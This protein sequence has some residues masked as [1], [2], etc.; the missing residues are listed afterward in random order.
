MGWYAVYRR[1]MLLLWKKIGRMGYVFPSIISPFIYFFAFGLGL[2]GRVSVEG[3]YLP[4]LA[5]GIIGMTVMTSGFQQTASS[6]SAG[7]LY[8]RHFHSLVLS[9][10]S[11]VAAVWGVILAG[12]S[13]A[14]IFGSLILVVGFISF[15]IGIK[16]SAWFAGVLLGGFCFSSLGLVVGMLVRQVDDISLVNSFFITPMTF[17]GGSFFPIQ[18]LPSWL[19][20]LAGWFPIGAIN[21]LLRATAWNGA[22][23]EAALILAGLGAVFFACG[24]YLYSHYSEY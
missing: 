1:E 20:F 13:R 6:I 14:A 4:F 18:N 21:T 9:P 8:F 2:S 16:S 24:V 7:R 3:G 19:S 22:V 15:G 10:V 5:S 12:M 17:F 11:H 23:L